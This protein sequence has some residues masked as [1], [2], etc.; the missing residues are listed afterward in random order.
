VGLLQVER[1][2]EGSADPNAAKPVDPNAPKCAACGRYHGGVNTEL[3][4][5]RAG[6]QRQRDVIERQRQQLVLLR[7]MLGREDEQS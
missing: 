2:G 5:L 6:L 7:A 4:C 3:H 1:K